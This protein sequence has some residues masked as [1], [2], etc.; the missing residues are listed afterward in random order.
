MAGRRQTS[1]LKGQ[2][3]A[4]VLAGDRT[5]G[6]IA[7]AYGRTLGR[8]LEAALHREGTG[9]PRRGDDG[10]QKRRIRDP[11]P[12]THA[13]DG[14]RGDVSAPGD[15]RGEPGAPDRPLSAP[16]SRD[17]AGGQRPVCRHHVCPSGMSGDPRNPLY[18]SQLL[19]F[20]CR[21]PLI[22][23]RQFMPDRGGVRRSEAL[24]A[25][26]CDFPYRHRS[27]GRAV[28]RPADSV[29]CRRLPARAR[30]AGPSLFVDAPGI[31]PP[32]SS[33]RRR[34]PPHSSPGCRDPVTPVTG[35]SH[36]RDRRRSACPDPLRGGARSA[37]G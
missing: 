5:P 11:D 25:S 4:E 19:I 28:L 27:A 23:V 2:V 21:C 3:V 6:Q 36:W 30:A 16:G 9:D 17:H 34:K 18:M 10:E 22:G 1:K 20:G 31:R 8:A 13:P 37:A 12:A 32:A 15:R 33:V 7:R 24:R 35:S 14:D 29:C 26:T